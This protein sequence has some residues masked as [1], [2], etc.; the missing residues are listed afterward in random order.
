MNVFNAINSVRYGN[1]ITQNI[2]ERFDKQ[3]SNYLD[4]KRGNLEAK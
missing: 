3:N 2:K 4:K 1:E